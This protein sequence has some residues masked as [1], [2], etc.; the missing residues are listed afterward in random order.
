MSEMV[1]ILSTPAEIRAA[2]EERTEQERKTFGASDASPNGNKNL[3]WPDTQPIPDGLPPVASF[4]D[5]LLPEAFR[6]WIMDISDR[7]QCPPDFAAVGA[8][9]AAGAIVGRKIG[10]RPKRRDDW[11][12][13]PNLWGAAVGRSGL[14]KSPA[15][16]EVLKPIK[17]LIAEADK[18][19]REESLRFDSSK[20]IE[21]ERRD[22]L[23]EK[24]RRELKAGK[25]PK[26]LEAEVMAAEGGQELAPVQRRY[27]T[28]DTTVEKLGELLAEN[29]NGILVFR[30]ELT[31]LLRSLDREGQ[32]CS[33]AFYLESWNGGGSFY[34]DRIGRGTILIPAACVSILGGIQP[35]PLADYMRDTVQGGK[36]DDGL[37]QRFQLAVYPDISPAWKNVDRWPNRSAKERAFEVFSQLNQLDPPAVG[38][39][40]NGDSA[41]PYLHFDNEAQELFDDWRGELEAKLRSG[42]ES[43]AFESHLAKY[44]SLIPSLALLIHLIDEGVGNV[45][46]RTLLQALAWGDY[47]ENHARR[48]YCPAH[49][50]EAA[51]AR[52]LA[53]RIQAKD[54]SSPFT[55]RDVYRHEWS[56]LATET[57]VAPA[58]ELLEDLGWLRSETQQTGGRPKT[59]YNVNP[60]LWRAIS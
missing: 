54:L 18:A 12:V 33:R 56:G 16:E 59:L 5:K 8:M 9:V 49:Y 34:F 30:D 17:R 40:E 2:V 28:N 7:M 47:L 60:K 43:P 35:G 57:D 3:S 41:I 24:V 14:M 52:S 53:K 39:E 55:A 10:I 11:F 22:L 38:V 4:S 32:E 21:K 6:G 37:I 44:R 45:T 51:T 48:I 46:Q 13:I 58:L 19:F 1:A 31:G 36:G 20:L 23:K 25:D 29:P 15:L 42:D 26:K 50:M 27:L